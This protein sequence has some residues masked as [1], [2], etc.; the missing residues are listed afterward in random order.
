[1]PGKEEDIWNHR[2]RREILCVL[3]KSNFTEI[4][5]RQRCLWTDWAVEIEV[6]IERKA[7]RK[8]PG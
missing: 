3:K 6:M 2:G 7:V 4:T 1:M 8:C 5:E